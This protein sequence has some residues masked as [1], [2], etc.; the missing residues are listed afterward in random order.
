MSADV[1]AVVRDAQEQLL[2][3]LDKLDQLLEAADDPRA[4][5][6]FAGITA[7]IKRAVE[8]QDLMGPFMKLATS[9][10][11]GF[12]LDFAASMLLDDVL[13]TAQTFSW[14]LSA[15]DSTPH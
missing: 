10:F 13:A 12:E 15:D 9:A 14:T 7:W 3:M 4:R 6:F 11:Q 5:E 8:T 2:P 1:D